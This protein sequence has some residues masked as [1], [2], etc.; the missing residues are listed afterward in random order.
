MTT[1][2][3]PPNQLLQMLDA[4][5]FDPTDIISRTSLKSLVMKETH[6][7]R[8]T[9]WLITSI[10]TVFETSPPA[11]GT[12]VWWRTWLELAINPTSASGLR[13][14]TIIHGSVVRISVIRAE[15]R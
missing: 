15:T 3:F 10:A 2:G 7:T 1:S 9:A 13:P 12:L 14:P 4:A 6:P 8:G 11:H 5:D